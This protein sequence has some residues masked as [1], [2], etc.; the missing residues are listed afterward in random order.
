MA[1]LL[2]CGDS[3]AVCAVDLEIYFRFSVDE[4]KAQIQAGKYRNLRT[5]ECRLLLFYIKSGE[6][7]AFSCLKV[8]KLC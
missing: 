1:H 2:L 4:L 6:D 7:S 5:F 3:S 8:R